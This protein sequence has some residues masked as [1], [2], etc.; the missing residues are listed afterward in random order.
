MEML[1]FCRQYQQEEGLAICLLLLPVTA[2]KHGIFQGNSFRN[3]TTKAHGMAE[4][5][6]GHLHTLALPESWTTW[7]KTFSQNIH[8]LQA[9]LWTIINFN[10]HS[11][12]NKGIIQY[13]Q[14]YA[15]IISNDLDT[16]QQMIIGIRLNLQNNY[17]P[18]ITSVDR[19]RTVM[20]EVW[21]TATVSTLHQRLIR[22]H[23]ICSPYNIR[24]IFRSTSPLM[25]SLPSQA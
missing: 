7:T 11:I 17:S 3:S 6:R 20:E 8:I 18:R 19:R 10:S 4:I 14:N 1:T 5:S 22:I 2:N 15:I 16:Y 21:K 12:Q 9:K 13:L 24:K 25:R 23:K